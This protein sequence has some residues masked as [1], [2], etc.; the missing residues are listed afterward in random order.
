MIPERIERRLVPCPPTD[1]VLWEGASD[2]AG[3]AIVWFEGN[4]RRVSR[5]LFKL[6]TGRWP[7]RD[8]EML[9][10]CDTPNCC[11]ERHHREGT[12]RQNERD[13]QAKGR[14]RMHFCAGGGRAA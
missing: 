3:Y 14:G 11:N 9:H 2:D 6:R 5:V 10:S 12:R 1:C 7:R 4:R 13:K 8:R